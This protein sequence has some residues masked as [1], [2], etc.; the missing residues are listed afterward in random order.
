M[1]EPWETAVNLADFERIASERLDAG[2][3]GY[4]AGGAADEV[5]LAD[6][7][8]AWRRW[9]L[10]P[11]VLVDVSEVGTGIELLGGPVSMPVCV[12]PV[13]FQ[14]LVDPDGEV[15]MA[16]AAAAAGTVMSLST[17]ATARPERGR[18]RRPGRSA[19]LPALLLPRRGR[20]QGADG[21]GDRFRVRGDPADRGRAGRRPARARQAD[22]VRGSLRP[23]R[24]QPRRR[25]RRPDRLRA[26]GLRPGRRRRSTGRTSRI[27]PRSARSRCWSRGC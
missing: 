14:R 23:P 21:G 26:R 7:V 19:L 2:T 10:R 13:A 27:S 6:N 11:R 5:T 22:R 18:G 17:I 9:R 1:S 3:L 16:R 4:F 8:A 24:A 20:D 25:L 12:A 15:A